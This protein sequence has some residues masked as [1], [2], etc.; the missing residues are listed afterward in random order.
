MYISTKNYGPSEGFAVAYRQWRADRKSGKGP[1][2]VY[3][4]DEIPGCSALHGYA[5][6][7]YFEF[8]STTLDAR[9]WVVD[10]GSL[11]P[12]KEFL[13]ETFDHTVLVASDDPFHA[14]Y[15][16]LREMGL[17]KLV[18][19]ENTGCEALAKFLCDFVNADFLPTHYP[20]STDQEIWCSMVEVRETPSNSA[21]YLCPTPDHSDG[22][23]SVSADKAKAL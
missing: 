14:E 13:K 17:L 9:N 16:R 3:T 7:F 10:F 8:T 23:G 22:T 1:N 20:N 4:H 21:K 18:E 6:S 5:M 19:V 2:E 15:V 12:L 11:R